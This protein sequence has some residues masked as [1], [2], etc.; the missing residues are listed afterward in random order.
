MKYLHVHLIFFRRHFIC[1]KIR[2]SDLWPKLISHFSQQENVQ[3]VD[4]KFEYL[5]IKSDW[6]MDKSFLV[7]KHFMPLCCWCSTAVCE[8][9][10]AEQLR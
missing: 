8:V 10:C 1:I 5:A 7:K 6:L 2:K 3:R 9:Y 4:W